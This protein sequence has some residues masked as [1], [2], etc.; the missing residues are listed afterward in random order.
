M[1]DPEAKKRRKKVNSPGDRLKEQRKNMGWSQKD[2][3]SKTG[4]NQVQISC[5]EQGKRAI[6]IEFLQSLDAVGFDAGYIVTGKKTGQGP[7]QNEGLIEV[8]PLLESAEG[9]IK[10]LKVDAAA[11]ASLRTAPGA[12]LSLVSFGDGFA[13]VEPLKDAQATVGRWLIDFG[14]ALVLANVE[15]GSSGEL[16]ASVLGNTIPARS[17][18]VV[19]RVLA[20]F[21]L[22]A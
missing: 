14:G 21:K 11:F 22:E 18:N 6:P 7:A 17:L 19:G 2:L 20:L 15:P 8:R 4:K 10:S 9:I 1:E 3:E 12:P 16:A 13:V 5:Y